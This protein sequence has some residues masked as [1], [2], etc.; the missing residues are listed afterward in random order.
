[1]VIFIASFILQITSFTS[2]HCLYSTIFLNCFL[3]ISIFKTNC[4][5]RETLT[6]IKEFPLTYHA[7]KLILGFLGF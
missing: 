7:P 6:I 1:M 5:V 4:K 2:L 3:S